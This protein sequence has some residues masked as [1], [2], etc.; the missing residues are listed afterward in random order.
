VHKFWD[1]EIDKG[2]S[3]EREVTLTE[4]EYLAD[5]KVKLYNTKGSHFQDFLD[6]VRSR[7]RPICDVEIG[8][9][10]VIACHLMNFG[11][12]YGANIKWDPERKKWLTR[13]KYRAGFGV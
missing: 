12:H 11:Y 6:C 1:K 4:R 2:T 5:A 13:D 9:S 10:S 8:A 3:M 7:K